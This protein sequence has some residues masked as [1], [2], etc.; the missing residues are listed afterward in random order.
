MI[1]FQLSTS[2][3]HC[4]EPD[5]F[6]LATKAERLDFLF[7]FNRLDFRKDRSANCDY[8]RKLEF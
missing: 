3:Q 5:S 2:E 6:L 8:F 1:V 4:P 7:L